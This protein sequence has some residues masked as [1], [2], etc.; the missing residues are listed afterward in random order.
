MKLLR[1]PCNIL[2]P[3]DRKEVIQ[4]SK[5]HIDPFCPV[6]LRSTAQTRYA[7][8]A[9]ISAPPSTSVGK[10]TPTYSLENAITNANTS[11]G[12]PIFLG[13]MRNTTTATANALPV[14][15]DGNE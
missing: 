11:T 4:R 9:P 6:F 7:I 1:R 13:H 2:L 14:C 3:R 12:T 5:F 8:T 10:C 15:P